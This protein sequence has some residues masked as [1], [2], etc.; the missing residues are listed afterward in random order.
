MKLQEI[1]LSENIQFAMLKF[2]NFHFY[3][4]FEIIQLNGEK[5]SGCQ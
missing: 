4:I 3:N 2:A 1:I 5:I